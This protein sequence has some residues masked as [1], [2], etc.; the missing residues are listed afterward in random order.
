MFKIFKK[1]RFK[2]GVCREDISF[3]TPGFPYIKWKASFHTIREV[4]LFLEYTHERRAFY[5]TKTRIE[6]EGINSIKGYLNTLKL[7]EQGNGK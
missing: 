7:E 6:I 4:E 3:G 5:D 2:C 1:K